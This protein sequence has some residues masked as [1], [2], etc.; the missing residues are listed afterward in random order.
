MVFRKFI[1]FNLLLSVSV[2]SVSAYASLEKE[3]EKKKSDGYMVSSAEADVMSNEATDKETSSPQ[4][5]CA[6]HDGEPLTDASD[7]IVE[8]KKCK[9]AAK[10]GDAE[11]QYKMGLH[12]WRENTEPADALDCNKSAYW[13]LKAA[14]QGHAGAQYKVGH[15][16]EI[17]LLEEGENMQKAVE[18]YAK[19]AA[20][21][22]AEAQHD[23]AYCY[24]EGNGVEQD[25]V[26]ALEFYK[27]AA[28]QGHARAQ[29]SMG[30]YIKK[31]NVA[32]AM[33]WW[34]K[35]AAQGD[36]DSLGE[37][38]SQ[39]RVGD[40]GV[41]QNVTK[42]I[43]LY[44]KKGKEGDSDAYYE[45]GVFHLKMVLE[46]DGFNLDIAK[47]YEC[48]EK[49]IDID[50]HDGALERCES[51]YLETENYPALIRIYEKAIDKRGSFYAE[52]KLGELYE[53]G[54]G[55]G[56]SNKAKAVNCYTNVAESN[57]DYSGKA[58]YELARLYFY[59]ERK[60]P[61]D[62][63]G[64]EFTKWL[65]S[66]SLARYPGVEVLERLATKY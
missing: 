8:Y 4:T 18:F 7:S 66:A 64:T 21:G 58:K 28:E 35:A 40:E 16:Y 12:F 20:Q 33:K 25:D 39:Y 22:H 3:E 53:K 31:E 13:H 23:L 10:K 1:M 30:F 38:A 24:E 11:A 26:K 17:G 44:E 49:A 37:L 34:E 42:S 57:N 6:V 61:A 60:N 36:V 46:E 5:L 29:Y 41:E 51:F 9:K 55:K 48:F 43:E 50:G 45:L 52:M 47:G 62:P 14:E 59:G 27:K 2:F 19:A 54:W 63:D 15:Y 56:T 32:E 65:T